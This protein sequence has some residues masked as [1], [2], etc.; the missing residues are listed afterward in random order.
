M[1]SELR[2]IG[3]AGVKDSFGVEASM[4]VDLEIG[5]GNGLYFAHRAINFP[6]RCLIG[7]ELR[8]KPLIQSIRRVIKAG[9]GNARVARYNAY[10]LPELFVVVRSM[11]CLSFSR[12]VGKIAQSQTPDHS[13][14]IFE[15]LV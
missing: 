11:T 1:K 5:T 4:P 2:N 7:L 10:L 8:Y 9:H 6:N 3:A 12:P 14:R 13:R 15:A